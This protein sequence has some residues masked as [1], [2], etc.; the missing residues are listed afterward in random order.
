MG[1]LFRITN[2]VL[3]HSEAL[4]LTALKVVNEDSVGGR[5]LRHRNCDIHRLMSI[6]INL[7]Y[8]SAQLS[9][10]IIV[11]SHLRSFI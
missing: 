11:K 9:A 2:G 7:C 1:L 4:C 10:V 3:I 8:S 5:L 6:N